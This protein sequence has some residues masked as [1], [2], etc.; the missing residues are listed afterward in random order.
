MS[1][2]VRGPQAGR[3]R[4]LRPQHLELPGQLEPRKRRNPCIAVA[5]LTQ[6]D[7][8]VLRREA[9][10][11]TLGRVQERERHD[12]QTRSGPLVARVVMSGTKKSPLRQGLSG[13]GKA[14]YKP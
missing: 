8:Q 1:P 7:R 2:R 11:D 4:R 3:V 6:N 14:H 5:L 12:D 13:N 10:R 9:E